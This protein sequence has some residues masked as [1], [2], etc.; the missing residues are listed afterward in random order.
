MKQMRLL[1]AAAVIVI[2]IIFAFSAAACAS[3][4]QRVKEALNK[5]KEYSGVE[6]KG[7]AKATVNI[8]SLGQ[9]IDIEYGYDIKARDK[10]MVMVADVNAGFINMTMEMYM[11]GDTFL[12][13]IPMLTD[14]YIDASNML[15]Q[16]RKEGIDMDLNVF[17]F[18]VEST[19]LEAEE[20]TIEFEG[21]D[22]NV[23]KVQVL[24][25]E[26]QL[27][28]IIKK[29]FA[30]QNFSTDAISGQGFN[31]AASVYESIDVESASY[32]LYI[33]KNNN[34]KRYEVAAV[35]K[36]V[37]QG[38][39]AAF[40]MKMEYDIVKTGDSVEV[41]LPQVD[42]QDIITIDELNNGATG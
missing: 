37:M 29:L 24:L 39:K 17:D 23:L 22:I 40:D 25:D 30:Q 5:A 35:F 42:P 9:D 41:A 36:A 31:E 1:K 10:N 18:N 32:T 28:D 13:H 19:E 4:N 2:I 27:N 8:E 33:D 3:A 34:V 38:E 16:V 15:E 6:I 11:V 12:M 20:A 7:T 21:S 26:D 14:K